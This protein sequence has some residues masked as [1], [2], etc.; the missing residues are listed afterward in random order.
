MRG[1]AMARVLIVDDDPSMGS[2][3]ANV[4]RHMGHEVSCQVR[5]ADGLEAAAA[6]DVDIVFL[7]VRLPDGNGAEALGEFRQLPSNPEVIIIT[8]YAD[9]DGAEYTLRHGAWDYIRKP[10]SLDVM[11]VTMLRALE[12][13]NQKRRVPA[14]LK[15]DA[16]IGSSRALKRALEL[17]AKAAATDSAVLITGQT[18]T[19]KEL[20]A[21]AIH[22]NSSRAKGPFVVV[23][24]AALPENLVES[25]LF[26]HE[27][28]AFTGADR[29]REG[30]VK[31]ADGGTLFL[32]EVGELPPAVQKRFLRVIQE[33]EFRPV[34]SDRIVGSD[35]RLVSATNCN[36]PEMV[37]SDNFRQDLLF[38]LCSID[39]ELPPLC[40]REEDLKE[41]ALFYINR[42]C[43]S[44]GIG[45]K[46]ISA[47]FLDVLQHYSW[48]GNVRELFGVLDKVLAVAQHDKIIYAYH[49]PVNIRLAGKSDELVRSGQCDLKLLEMGTDSL[50]PFKE[51]QREC[52][53]RYIT[54]LMATVGGDKKEACRLSGLS[55]SHLYNLLKEYSS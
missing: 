27:R 53:R 10:A 20:F 37:N 2:A 40:Q 23:D 12:Y 25:V 43:D 49:L 47:C 46:G 18:G 16:I 36:L 8:G 29:S 24:C 42:Y 28:G 26:G 1:V 4:V 3:L 45:I 21:R 30:L 55:Q 34:G 39:I 11:K 14:L 13:R 31:Q 5:L 33:Q 44:Q 48:P 41:L 50:P 38:R 6:Q 7:D 35:F 9:V 15:R 54:K 22:E 19:G 51:Y 32:D 17:V 52:G